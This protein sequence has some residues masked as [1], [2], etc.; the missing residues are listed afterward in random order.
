M[1]LNL[2][3]RVIISRLKNML[4]DDPKEN[5]KLLRLTPLDAATCE[6]ENIGMNSD[7][8]SG[9]PTLYKEIFGK[10]YVQ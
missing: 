7:I 3:K 8:W 1:T 6:R 4:S 2:T 10:E 5:R 9:F